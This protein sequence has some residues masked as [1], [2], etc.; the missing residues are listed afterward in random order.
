MLEYSYVEDALIGWLT[1][2]YLSKKC[3]AFF[4]FSFP[5][6]QAKTDQGQTYFFLC[7]LP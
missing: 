3:L 1:V 4:F 5:L 2:W 7:S 6:S